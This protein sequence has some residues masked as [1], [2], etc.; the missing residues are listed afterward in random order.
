[1]IEK[2]CLYAYDC[3]STEKCRG[4]DDYRAGQQTRAVTLLRQIVQEMQTVVCS[5]EGRDVAWFERRIKRIE[6]ELSKQAKEDGKVNRDLYA[7]C[8]SA[9]EF[10]AEY[11]ERVM[12]GGIVSARKRHGGLMPGDYEL[13]QQLKS[14]LTKAEGKERGV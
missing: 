2:D 13:V 9:L 14:A 5:G 6:R 4:C 7:A 12:K 3:G 1:M 10:V 11:R 8:Q